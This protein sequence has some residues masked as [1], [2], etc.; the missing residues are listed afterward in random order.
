ML[1][2]MAALAALAA[3]PRTSAPASLDL[4]PGAVLKVSLIGQGVQIYTCSAKPDAVSYSWAFT[5]PEADLF[6]LQGG[7]VEGRHFAGPT[8]QSLDGS[9]VVGRLRAKAPSPDGRGVDWLLLDATPSGQGFFG[10]IAYVRR[11]DTTGGVAPASG[12]T[13]DQAGKVARVPYS[14]T[15]EFYTAGR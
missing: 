9:R 12:C 8:W 7:D 14:A 11:V 4:P 6:D 10:R 15:Y 3:A 1:S 13:L 5:A 2:L